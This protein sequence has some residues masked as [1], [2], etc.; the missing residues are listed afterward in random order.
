MTP[1][2]GLFSTPSSAPCKLKWSLYGL[3][4]DPHAWFEKFRSTL[5]HISF[6]QSQY[7]SSLFLCKTPTGLVL[8]LVYVD[9]IVITGID[10]NLI[11]HLKHNLQAS[12]HMK[13]LRLLTYFLGL[14]VHTD[15]SGIFLNQHKYT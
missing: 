15:S 2:L 11:S 5:F 10:S 9:D 4:Q 7:D 1:P 14:E 12:F 6:V 13:D 3:K 8:L